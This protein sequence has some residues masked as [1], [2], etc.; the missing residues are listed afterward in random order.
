PASFATMQDATK[1]RSSSITPRVDTRGQFFASLGGQFFISPDTSLSGDVED[2]VY[3][4]R[5]ARR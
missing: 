4:G 5:Y 3:P 1:S 2:L